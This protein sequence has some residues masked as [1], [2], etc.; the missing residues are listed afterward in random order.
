MENKKDKTL[1]LLNGK[2]FYME[3]QT[4][5]FK[6]ELANGLVPDVSVL[7]RGLMGNNEIKSKKPV[8]KKKTEE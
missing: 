7:R 3:D 2:F 8:K 5:K 6:T 1:C 4:E